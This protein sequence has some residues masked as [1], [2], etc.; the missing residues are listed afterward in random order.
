[1][2]IADLDDVARGAGVYQRCYACHSVDPN[3]RVKLQGEL[4]TVAA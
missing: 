2:A 1:M 3:K 4:T